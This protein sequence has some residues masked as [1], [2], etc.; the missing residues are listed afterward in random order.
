MRCTS[1]DRNPIQLEMTLK[2]RG[3]VTLRSCDCT[4]RWFHDGQPV[5]LDHVLAAVPKRG[6]RAPH[7]RRVDTGVVRAAESRA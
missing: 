7:R 3:T 5:A 2:N 1:C 6:P 4:R